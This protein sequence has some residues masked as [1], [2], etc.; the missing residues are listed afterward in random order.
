MTNPPGSATGP[1]A[2]SLPVEMVREIVF[3]ANRTAQERFKA[4]F[5]ELTERVVRGITAA[6]RELDLFRA[7]VL[8]NLQ[9]ATLEL[10]FHSSINAVLCSTHHLVSGF[11]IAAGN[12]MRH[13]TE[14]VAMALL[15]VEPSL[16]VLEAFTS[17]RRNYP[18]QKAPTKLKQKRVRASLEKRIA[19]DHRAWETVLEIADLYDQ[20]SHASGLALAH[21]LMVNTDNAM[22]VGSEYDPAKREAYESDLRRRVTAAES[23]AHLIHVVTGVLPKRGY[24]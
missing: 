18:V 14:S 19:F 16:G 17:H 3:G 11:P 8:G 13:Y 5:P 7:S 21:Q 22:I 20:L 12:L 10:F 24:A 4:E 15:C 9:T 1:P 2:I 23:L 6:S